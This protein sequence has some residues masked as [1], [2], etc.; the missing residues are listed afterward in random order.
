[1]YIVICS[2]THVRRC[3]FSETC[4]SLFVP[5]DM[6]MVIRSLIHINRYLFCNTCTLLFVMWYIHILIRYLIH[7]H[8]YLLCDTCTFLFVL[9]YICFAIRSVTRVPSY[10]F[11]DRCSLQYILSSLVNDHE[12]HLGVISIWV[13]CQ[14]I[15]DTKLFTAWI[16]HT[17]DPPCISIW[18]SFGVVYVR[19]EPNYEMFKTGFPENYDWQKQRFGRTVVTSQKK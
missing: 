17:Q 1:M 2:L 10:L 13:C 3:L 18:S 12:V 5:W 6:Y 11:S 7:V 15:E 4:T 16:Y 14:V 9:W 8:R 19:F